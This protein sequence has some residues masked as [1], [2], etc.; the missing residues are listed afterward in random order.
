M[1]MICEQRKEDRTGETGRVQ[2]AETA[3]AGEAVGLIL[4]LA[5]AVRGA[6]L[7]ARGTGK[8]SETVFPGPSVGM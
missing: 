6:R 8:A 1:R 2:R 4:G 7:P 5:L 3:A